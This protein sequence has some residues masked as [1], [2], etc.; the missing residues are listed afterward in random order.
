MMLVLFCCTYGG[1]I[2]KAEDRAAARQSRR[3]ELSL[4][5]DLQ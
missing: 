4:M 1:E 2:T 3:G 5:S